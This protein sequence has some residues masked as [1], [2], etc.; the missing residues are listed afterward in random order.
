MCC[1]N[2][3]TGP[4][5]RGL[6]IVGN[7]VHYCY[8]AFDVKRSLLILNCITL[9]QMYCKSGACN[10]SLSYPNG[11]YTSCKR[12]AECDDFGSLYRHIYTFYSL[13]YA[14][15]C[16]VSSLRGFVVKDVLELFLQR[17]VSCSD[18]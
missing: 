5:A 15:Q 2:R 14:C 10:L 7:V 13:F 16:S 18:V 3:Q 9:H 1:R 12:R 17:D 11:A 8:L 6:E 4:G